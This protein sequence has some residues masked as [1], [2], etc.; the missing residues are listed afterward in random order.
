MARLARLLGVEAKD[1]PGLVTRFPEWNVEFFDDPANPG[2]V[3]LLAV[4]VGEPD[5]APFGAAMLE[6]S[7]RWIA[8]DDAAWVDSMR[9]AMPDR[10]AGV[11]HPDLAPDVDV[12][13]ESI[14]RLFTCAGDLG[15]AQRIDVHGETRVCVDLFGLSLL[16]GRL[17]PAIRLALALRRVDQPASF[18][19]AIEREVEAIDPGLVA[20]MR[21]YFGE[22]GRAD[23]T[24]A[25]VFMFA[26]MQWFHGGISRAPSVPGEPLHLSPGTRNPLQLMWLV[27]A[28]S[29]GAVVCP[30]PVPGVY[31]CAYH[32]CQKVFLSNKL[33]VSGKLRFCCPEHGKRFYAAR[34]MKEKA[35]RTR[36]ASQP[37]ED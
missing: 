36:G 29:V 14:R 26:G 37:S 23:V 13:A 11:Q 18:F 24:L 34:R 25:R 12:L 17:R 7:L 27:G 28:V 10:L 16:L 19:R 32:R 21:A 30:F 4:G 9:A 22:P 33:E 5:V 35:A 6:A 31:Q 8:S 15:M 20:E 3:Q 1:A 2:D